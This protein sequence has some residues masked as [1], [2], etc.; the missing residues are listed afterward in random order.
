MSQH[1]EAPLGDPGGDRFLTTIARLSA[2]AD[3]AALHVG[4]READ[5]L[6]RGGA[7]MNRAYDFAAEGG[8]PV[9]ETLCVPPADGLVLKAPERALEAKGWRFLAV[10]R[11]TRRDPAGYDAL[12]SP[13]NWDTRTWLAVPPEGSELAARSFAKKGPAFA[14][15]EAQVVEVRP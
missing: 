14:W 12:C 5:R 8:T 13:L 15:A 2:A 3:V 1:L 6:R 10:P 7:P 9:D 11:H 4:N